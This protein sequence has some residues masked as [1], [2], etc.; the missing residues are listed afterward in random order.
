MDT[1]YVKRDRDGMI[2]MIGRE[3]ARGMTE[4]LAVD[5]PAV[6]QFL[7][8]SEEAAAVAEALQRSDAELV[9]EIGRA[10]CR[11]RVFRAV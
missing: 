11:E 8:A 9:R 3:P 6:Q 4:A 5:D 10:S 2:I 1:V 7:G